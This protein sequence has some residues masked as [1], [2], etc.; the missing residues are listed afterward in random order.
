MVRQLDDNLVHYAAM[1]KEYLGSDVEQIPGAGAAGG[2]G[3]G[4]LAFLGAEL[5]R[6]VDIVIEATGLASQVR[7]ADLVITGEGRIDSQTIYGKTPM[8]VAKT[9]KLYGVPVIGLAGTLSD[10]H[11]VVHEHGIDMVFTI[12]PGVCSLDDAMRQA[13]GNMEQTARNIAM[14]LK[15]GSNLA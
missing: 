4:V 13:A 15:C 14:A 3:A 11:E 9:A 8:G 2:L 12:V 7:D 10:G 5:K 6:G 1:I